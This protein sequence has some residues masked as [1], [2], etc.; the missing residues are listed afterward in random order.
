M[1]DPRPAE[2][3]KEHEAAAI[4]PP[5]PEPSPET[6]ETPRA[7]PEPVVSPPPH[8][9]TN[10][11]VWLVALLVIVIAGIATSPFWAPA[12][13]PLL[14][15]G[16]MPPHDESR[17]TA[18]TAR[19]D[20]LE[21]LSGRLDR[22]D[23]AR[24]QDQQ[25]S[26][27]TAA[28]LQQL[29]RRIVALEARPAAPLGD[30]TELRQQSAKLGAAAA[31]LTTRTDALASRVDAL[32]KTIK[33]QASADATDTGLTLTLLQ[34]RAAL[35]TARPFPAEYD[36]FVAL[37]RT[38]PEISAAAAPLAG[39]AKAGVAS[40]AVLIRRLGELAGAI[41]TAQEAPGESDWEGQ[42]LSRLRSLVTIRRISGAGQSAPESTVGNAQLLLAQGDLAGAIG[43]LETL[44]GANAEAARPWLEMARARLAAETVLQKAEMLLAARLS[45]DRDASQSTARP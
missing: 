40:R 39:A 17:I 15:W 14:P 26:G 5:A 42:I 32:E 18:L 2:P 20:Q 19:L 3:P 23:A 37:A 11:A 10:T 34:I 38:R 33:A 16:E 30:I 9:S 1:S 13:T 29:D 36:A 31:D 44:G 45:V 22:L 35:D 7:Q 28:T 6:I 27:A 21:A 43:A 4:P 24:N 25:A 8:R 41:A 12:I